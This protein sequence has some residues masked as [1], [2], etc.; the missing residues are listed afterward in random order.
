[1]NYP[2]PL[3]TRLKA[4]GDPTR[5]AL[6]DVL[7]RGTFNVS[8]LLF[9]VDQ[10]QSTVSRHLRILTDAGLLRSKKEGR[11]VYYRLG[12]PDPLV[13]ACLDEFP[14]LRSEGL[15]ARLT[16]IW[17]L[18]RER[19]RHFFDR[20]AH[21][22]NGGEAAFLG[23]PDCVPALLDRLP[24][25]TAIADVGT[26]AGRLL[27]RLCDHAPHV[28]GVDASPGMLA[29]AA[30]G[31]PE[32]MEPNIEFR[33]GDLSHLPLANAEVDA[34]IAHMV[35]H[36][37]PDPE[38]A[39]REL[40]RVIRPGGTVLIGDFLP[41]DNEWMREEMA[42]QWLGFAEEDVYH[43]LESAQFSDI[44]FDRVES[45]ESQMATF[46]ATARQSHTSL[47]TETG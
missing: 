41:H 27:V 4:L 6:L 5:L 7:S 26:G 8:E 31:L 33:L 3:P 45:D 12:P 16:S 46:V 22:L 43:W 35:L 2:S 24:R 13:S 32:A 10:G 34:A 23:S 19:S 14:E 15:E 1:M 29:Q 25:C 42:D 44:T 30:A 37:A 38:V 20:A 28:I 40:A 21:N 47:S 9:A 17:Q 39:L 36:H 11:Q 18:R